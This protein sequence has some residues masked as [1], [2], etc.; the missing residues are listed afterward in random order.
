ML[1]LRSPDSGDVDE[2]VLC[3]EMPPPS[4]PPPPLL[5]PSG[6]AVACTTWQSA[7]SPSLTSAASRWPASPAMV[8]S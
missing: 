8:M 3:G 5:T 2:G 4:W 7:L 1:R 6:S